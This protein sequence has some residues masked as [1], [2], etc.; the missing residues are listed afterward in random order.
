[1]KVPVASVRSP[2]RNRRAGVDDRGSSTLEYAI[3]FPALLLLIMAGVQ[4]GLFYHARSIAHAAAE[5][6]A[7]TAA[8]QTATAAMGEATAADFADRVGSG[9]FTGVDVDVS[10]SRT[11][12]TATVSG[13]AT[14]LIPGTTWTVTQTVTRPVERVTSP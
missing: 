10:R 4:A 1:M 13:T 5:E 2:A 12:V 6:G 3:L 7:R 14:S 11:T 9:L 8:A